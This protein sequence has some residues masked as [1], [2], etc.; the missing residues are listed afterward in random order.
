MPRLI[1]CQYCQS[2]SITTAVSLICVSRARG[3]CHLT[4]DHHADDDDDGD[5]DVGRK[6]VVAYDA[7]E[8]SVPRPSFLDLQTSVPA[9]RA[10]FCFFSPV[11]GRSVLMPTLFSD[12]TPPVVGV[13]YTLHPHWRRESVRPSVDFPWCGSACG[14]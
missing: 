2:A 13:Q 8:P 3:V 12:P 1:V 11:F 10:L 7:P 9:P 5:G 14:H 6:R 4:S